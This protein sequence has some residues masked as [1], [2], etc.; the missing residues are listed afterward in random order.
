MTRFSKLIL[1]A[2]G[3]PVETDMRDI[4]QSVIMNCPNCI[5]L[6]KHYRADG[7]CMCDDPLNHDMTEWGYTWDTKTNMWTGE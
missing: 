4:Q 6:A 3:K 2:Q 7:S 5:L 1:D